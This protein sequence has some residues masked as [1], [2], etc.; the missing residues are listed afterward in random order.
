MFDCVQKLEPLQQLKM[1]I[2]AIVI[3]MISDRNQNVEFCTVCL[4]LF[5]FW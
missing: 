1:R 2:S 4:G 3:G 5:V